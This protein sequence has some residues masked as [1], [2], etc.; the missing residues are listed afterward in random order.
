MAL[1]LPGWL[2]EAILFLGYEFPGTNEDSLQQWAD[3]LSSM[4][5]VFES[6]HGS[7]DRAIAHVQSHNAG[8]ALE[9]FVQEVQSGNSD[10]QALQRFGQA[11]Q[12]AAMGCDVC[13]VATVV[14]KGVILFQLA[15]LA[16]A[17]A[18]GPVSFMLKRS[19]EYAIDKAVEA[20]IS[21][22]LG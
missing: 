11:T 22:I 6:S 9:A 5:R 4:Q 8:P 14:L 7:L 19:V 10:V 13:A 3:Q 12:I 17:I 2:M 1:T 21:Q 16:P 20:A 15:M 18:A